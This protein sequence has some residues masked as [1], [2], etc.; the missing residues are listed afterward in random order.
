MDNTEI[1]LDLPAAGRL[2]GVAELEHL[3][4]EISVSFA[5]SCNL[6][7]L[8]P[9]LATG[10]SR[11][12]S[13]IEIEIVSLDRTEEEAHIA[14]FAPALA[15]R[16]TGT[17]SARFLHR[18]DVVGVQWCDPPEPARVSNSPV[19]S[20]IKVSVGK[21][22]LLTLS[23]GTDIAVDLGGEGTESLVDALRGHCLR[24]GQ[25]DAVARVSRR[26]H[27]HTSDSPR[28][29]H[30]PHTDQPVAT[31]AEPPPEEQDTDMTVYSRDTEIPVPTIEGALVD[32]ISAA[33]QA[34]QGRIYGETGA[35]KLL[36]VKPSTLQSKMRKL[37]IERT[38][39]TH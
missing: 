28:E 25:L 22:G 24:M 18:Q 21:C 37:G 32:C 31:R 8:M 27:R 6:R 12:C 14:A 4:N 3:L 26:A 16:W 35:A 5:V 7:T 30:R 10:M 17:R 2:I 33:L 19:E 23:F 38:R 9:R 29:T 39:F 15:R 20:Q 13:L 1:S 11:Y 36:G 34:T